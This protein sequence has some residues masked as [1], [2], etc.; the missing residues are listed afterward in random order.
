MSRAAVSRP[1]IRLAA[2]YAAIFL[3]TAIQLPFWP[4]WLASRG[5]TSEQIGL[6]FAAAICVK[7]FATPAVG[8][9]ADRTGRYRSAM[10]VLA[11]AALAGYA[12]LFS[13]G[14]LW[15][16]ILLNLIALSAQPAL[17][18]ST[19]HCRRVSAAGS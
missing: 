4:V 8:A 3:V 19:R 11:A 13:I 7:V 12:G 1:A 10:V 5:L 18:A 17:K 15:L 6:L 16:L 2:F 9:V 14:S